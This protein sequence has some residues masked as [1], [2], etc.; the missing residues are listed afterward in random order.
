MTDIWL[1]LTGLVAG[2]LSGAV[3]FGGGMI[4]L[5]VLTYFYGVEVAVPVSTIAQMLSNLSKMGFGWKD[6]KWKAAGQ[7]LL[8][9][10]PLTALGAIG[11]AFADKVLMTRILAVVLIVFSIMKIM[12]KLHLPH[13]K[14][15]M[16]IGGGVT[17]VVNGMMGISGPL[18]SA[19]FLTLDL[20]P[21]AY[22]ASE[23]TAAAAMHLVKT[24]V[25][26][27]LHLLDLT[28]LLRGVMIGAAMMLGNYIAMKLIG[29][30]HNKLYQ[31]I[32]AITMIALSLWL[33]VSAG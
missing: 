32:V 14:A 27:K 11:F 7:F 2:L 12:G 25:Y 17:G 1:I 16:L 8:S 18:S 19:V 26:G 29:R 4:L 6:I 3:G 33:F 23:A 28:G 31:K 15:T 13:G 24:V 30:L 5:P 9:A 20:A 21:V 10:A 22:I